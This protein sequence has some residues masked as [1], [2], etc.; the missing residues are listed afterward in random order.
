[1][2]LGFCNDIVSIYAFGKRRALITC[3]NLI[4]FF[5]IDFSLNILNVYSKVLIF[6]NSINM[7]AFG[8]DH[9]LLIDGNAYLIKKIMWFILGEI[10]PS[11]NWE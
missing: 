9:A 6:E 2:A 7:F 1:M 3:D 11:V 4:Y 10:V 5:G 8:N